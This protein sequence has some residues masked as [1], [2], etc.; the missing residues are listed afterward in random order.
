MGMPLQVEKGGMLDL[1][2]LH[3]SKAMSAQNGE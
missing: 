2:Y 1:F 3:E